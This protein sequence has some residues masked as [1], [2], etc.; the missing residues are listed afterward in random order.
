MSMF[1]IARQVVSGTSTSV[2]SFSNIPQNFT[3][4][5]IKIWMR[6]RNSGPYDAIYLTPY[7]TVTDANA[8]YRLIYGTGSGVGTNGYTGQFY[9]Q[10]GF[11]PAASITSGV[12]AAAI[13]DI[14]DYAS[15][16]KNKTMRSIYGWDDN[17]A[18]SGQPNIGMNSGVSLSLGT[19]A[20]SGLTFGIN[21]AFESGTRIDL[22]GI[23]DSPRTGA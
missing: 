23:T 2:I 18:T 14:L 1:P 17:G 22:Y 19:T 4:L 15:T 20:L 12:W 13:I 7:S 21:N 11:V 8:A 10:L 3:H 9:P 5:Q 6:S 16:S